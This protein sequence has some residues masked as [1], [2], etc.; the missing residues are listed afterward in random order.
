MEQSGGGFLLAY[1]AE[2]L[3]H[4]CLTLLCLLPCLASWDILSGEG[5]SQMPFS[6]IFP[7]GPASYLLVYV[8]IHAV[9]YRY[10][11]CLHSSLSI[12]P[13]DGTKPSTWDHFMG[14]IS[15]LSHR[16]YI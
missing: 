7:Q 8:L 11:W 12:A 9:M 10:G 6:D 1:N 14:N 2:G 5:S 15:H 3:E 13:P 4:G 16:I